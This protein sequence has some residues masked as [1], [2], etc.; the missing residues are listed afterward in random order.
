MGP[1]VVSL[2]VD[3][4]TW[5]GIKDISVDA[6]FNHAARSFR[7]TLAPMVS[8][9]QTFAP[10]TAIEIMFNDDLACAG[11]VDRLQPGFKRLGIAG[12]SKAQDFIDCAAIDQAGTGNFQNQTLLQI[13][14]SFDRFGVGVTTDQQ[15][16]PIE[17]YQITPGEKA[18]A[19]IEKKAREQ[20]LT[21]AGQPDGSIKITK[22]GS[23]RHAGGL[24]E[25]INI[26]TDEC[27]ADLDWSHRHSVVI[28]RGQ[29]AG[30]TDAS[31]LTIEATAQD[32]AVGRYRPLVHIEDGDLDQEDAQALA[33]ARLQREAGRSLKCRVPVQGFRDEAGTLW[34]P[35]NL[36]WIESPMLGLTQVMLVKHAAFRR[37]KRGAVTHLGLVDPRA[38]GGTSAKGSQSGSDGDVWDID[39]D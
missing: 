1:E 10:G 17:S 23:A 4:Q 7:L 21:L 19:A 34:T 8:A 11:Y 3:G 9:L 35:G 38:F 2:N 20:G 39:A 5:R 28:V 24:F 12:R 25:G 14:Q 18:F 27:E 37:S 30:G 29:A 36:V 13:A 26:L 16:D 32:S 22:P 33:T 15:L 6:A 31:D